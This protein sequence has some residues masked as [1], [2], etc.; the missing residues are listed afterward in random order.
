M[1]KTYHVVVRYLIIALLCGVSPLLAAETPRNPKW[2][3]PLY[4]AG[5]PNLHRVSDRLYRGAQPT[6][7]GMKRLHDMGIKTVIDLR[8][9]H[10]D[11]DEIGKTPLGYAHI[12]MFALLP[13][14][15]DIIAALRVIN[16][17]ERTPVFVHCLHGADRTGIV[18]AA[19]RIVME[20]WTK[21]EAIEE[22]TNGGFG[23]HAIFKNLTT[24]IRKLDVERIKQAL[25]K[26]EH[27]P[28]QKS[29]VRK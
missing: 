15:D 20:G 22:M 9:F 6:A 26:E 13:S 2:A 14:H 29:G 27:H 5:L 18:I 1:K 21:D 19:Y 8:T 23:H 10:S 3:T 4:E 17:T 24:F 16:D 11:R 7:A 28:E 12:S 25:E